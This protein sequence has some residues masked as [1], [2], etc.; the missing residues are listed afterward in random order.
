MDLVEF[1]LGIPL[2]H[3]VTMSR[4]TR[5]PIALEKKVFRAR[6]LKYLPREVVYR[7]KGFTVSM[8]RDEI[9]QRLADLLPTEVAGVPVNDMESRVAAGIFRGWCELNGVGL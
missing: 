5:L 7:K 4:E 6:A 8:E 3:R 9:T 1:C 2:R